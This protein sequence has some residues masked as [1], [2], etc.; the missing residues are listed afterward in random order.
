[1]DSAA[2]GKCYATIVNTD[3]LSIRSAP[4]GAVVGKLYY[5]DRVEILEQRMVNGSLWGRT[6]QGWLCMNTYIHTETVKN[7][8][9]AATA[10]KTVTA[11]CLNL[12][13]AAGIG[14]TVVGQLYRGAVIEI[15]EEK[16]INGV[17][18]GRVG[19]VWICLNYVS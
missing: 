5:G 13:D 4:D 6:Y 14:S 11:S 10:K 7:S 19:E 9:P 16:V 3:T 2:D 18:W 15:Q 1:M 12:R 17:L 8:E